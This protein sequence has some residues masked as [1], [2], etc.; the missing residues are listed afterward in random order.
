MNG[1]F[2]MKLKYPAEAFALG[3][4][5]FSSG[6]REAFVSGILI[7]LSV[8]FAEFLENLLVKFLPKW[9]LSLCLYLA[10]GAVCSSA[11]LIG[12]TFLG[13]LLET[14]I[15][16]MTFLI[17]LLSAYHVLSRKLETDYGDILL[18][19]ASIWGF[20]IL[21]AIFREFMGSGMVFGNLILQADFQS[22]AFQEVTFAFLASG[23]ALAFTNSLWK[24]DSPKLQALFIIV[25]AVILFR[26]FSMDSFGE[27]AET[28]WTILVPLV[29]F[30]SVKMTLRFSQFSKAYRG[31]PSDM[32]AAGFI[33]MILS[34]Y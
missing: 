2:Y 8:V 11:F 14:Q 34:I 26:P 23:L 12:F 6:M 32:L 22:K 29:M 18:Q 30:L 15:W 21:L 28:I 7:I 19:S 3:I 33:Y 16:L 20:W 13:T 5:L 25:P 9:S 31:L 1:G 24:I 10:T 4:V 27:I 17:G